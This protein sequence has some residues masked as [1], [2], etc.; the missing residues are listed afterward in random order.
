MIPVSSVSTGNNIKQK[1]N[2]PPVT[3]PLPTPL[4]APTPGDAT[5]NWM[6]TLPKEIFHLRECSPQPSPTFCVVH[7]LLQLP[8]FKWRVGEGFVGPGAQALVSD[9]LLAHQCGWGDGPFLWA[10]VPCLWLWVWFLLLLF[11][12]GLRLCKWWK[13]DHLIT[14]M[15]SK[16]SL[17][18]I[19]ANTLSTNLADKKK[20]KNGIKWLKNKTK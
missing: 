12:A 20:N 2:W 10:T 4:S 17:Y 14:D 19:N 9:G 11:R 18:S 8:L 13:S 5:L 7:S 1:Q 15:A 16:I 3:R 6:S